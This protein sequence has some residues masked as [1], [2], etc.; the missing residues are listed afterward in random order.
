MIPISLVPLFLVLHSVPD[1]RTVRL[2]GTQLQSPLSGSS[3]TGLLVIRTT[4][5]PD[6]ESYIVIPRYPDPRYPD[7]PDNGENILSG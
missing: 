7:C 3:L 1:I 5:S 4:G 2:T 6:N